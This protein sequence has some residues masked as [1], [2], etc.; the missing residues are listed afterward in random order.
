MAVSDSRAAI[1][2]PKGLDYDGLVETKPKTGTEDDSF[3]VVKARIGKNVMAVLDLAGE[4]K[5]CPREAA[6]RIAKE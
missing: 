1:Y 6:E 2:D 4:E 5:L 3:K